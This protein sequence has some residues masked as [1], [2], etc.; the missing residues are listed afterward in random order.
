MM[1]QTDMDD[2]FAILMISINTGNRALPLI[3]TVEKGAA[4]IGFDKQR[5]LLE[6]LEK[7]M[8]KHAKHAKIVLM[9]DRFYPSANLFNWLQEHKWGYR[10]RLKGNFK[11]DI[12]NDD[13]KTTK[14][15]ASGIKYRKEIDVKLF[16]SGVKTN[17]GVL[18]EPGH[19]EPWI[20]AM[21]CV[22][23]KETIL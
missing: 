15:L 13:V 11:V 10:L 5:D 16:Q 19:D 17:I 22:P 8:P 21:E 20:I 1:D 18:H 7:L 2:R 9:A 23:T 12:G 6:F 4:N 14:D 3:W